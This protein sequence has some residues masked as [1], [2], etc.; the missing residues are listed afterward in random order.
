MF[1]LVNVSIVSTTSPAE[2]VTAYESLAL[3]NSAKYSSADISAAF[4]PSVIRW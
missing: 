2:S 1:L 3:Y 4:L